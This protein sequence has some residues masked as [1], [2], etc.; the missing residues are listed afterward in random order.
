MAMVQ[1]GR[2]D[3]VFPAHLQGAREV[4]AHAPDPTPC[5]SHFTDVE[6]EGRGTRKLARNSKSRPF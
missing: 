1:V 5:C 3:I 6:T 4:S 2:R